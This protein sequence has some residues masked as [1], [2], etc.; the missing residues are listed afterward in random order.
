MSDMRLDKERVLRETF[1][2][3]VEHHALI[4]STNDR[5][6]ECASGGAQSLPFLIVA[7]A[8]TAGRGRG[9]NRWW[10]GRGS[11][12][13]T[14]LVDL[15]ALG[16]DRPWRVLTG[17]AAGVAVVETV[18]SR[19]PSHPVGLHWPNDVY[20]AGRKLA[21]I[22][23]EVIND[24]FHAIGIGLNTNNSVAAAPAEL[25]ERATTLLDLTAEPQDQTA[26]LVA[27][28][29]NL[30]RRLRQMGEAPEKLTAQADA[31]CLQRGEELTLQTGG[32]SLTGRCVGIAA[33]GALVLD[34]PNGREKVFSGV[35][36]SRHDGGTSG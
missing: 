34:T 6:R 30:E 17:I 12:A 32:R 14:L 22:L 25:R 29:R 1:V 13:C 35:T 3:R 31:I 26:V 18:A 21:G 19:L 27:M 20:A 15:A 33:D 7:D 2:A 9:G 28:M 5:A 23:V 36:R 16:V 24:R 8:Q 11:L 4:G 10:T